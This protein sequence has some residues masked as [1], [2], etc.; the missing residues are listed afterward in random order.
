MDDLVIYGENGVE[1]KLPLHWVVCD[2]CRGEG[3]HTNPSIDGNGI[4][5]REWAEMCYEDESF[6]QNYFSGVY[7][8]TC[9]ECDGRRVTKAVNLGAM[10]PEHVEAYELQQQE[11]RRQELDNY[12]ERRAGA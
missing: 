6:A 3:K 1:I 7:D 4:T 12:Y 8:V 9:E 2:R 10:S 5:D 11:R